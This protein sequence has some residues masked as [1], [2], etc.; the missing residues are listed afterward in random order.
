MSKVGGNMLV[1]IYENDGTI[2]KILKQKFYDFAD[3]TYAP[4][5]K[6]EDKLFWASEE[7]L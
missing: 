1:K 7:L 2:R 3:K 4:M 6:G 5:L